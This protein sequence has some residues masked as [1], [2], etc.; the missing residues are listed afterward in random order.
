MWLSHTV[1]DCDQAWLLFL[2][3]V[4][5]GGLGCGHY[6]YKGIVMEGSPAWEMLASPPASVQQ[7]FSICK[8]SRTL[9]AY[10]PK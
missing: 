6:R 8:D 5:L 2:G 9:L 10:I 1:R 7:D 3:R 4:S